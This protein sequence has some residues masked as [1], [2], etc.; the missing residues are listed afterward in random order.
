MREHGRKRRWTALVIG[1]W[2]E[3]YARE[4]GRRAACRQFE[5]RACAAVKQQ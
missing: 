2:E 3:R 4:L 5:R 1:L